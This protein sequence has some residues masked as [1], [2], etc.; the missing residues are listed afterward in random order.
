MQE[1]RCREASREYET[2]FQLESPD[3][4]LNYN[5]AA[6]FECLKQPLKA[7]EVLQT[8]LAQN[9]GAPA[10][11]ALM[12]MVEAEAGKWQEGLSALDKAQQLDANYAPTYAYRGAVLMGLRQPELAEKEFEKCLRL[13][14]NNTI[15]RRGWTSLHPQGS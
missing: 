3:F 11:H 6:A 1:N 13:D 14:P 10:N 15:A 7:M 2:A 12:G 9:P 4:T 5:R 8:A